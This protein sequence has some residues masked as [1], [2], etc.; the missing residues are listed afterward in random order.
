MR[1]MKFEGGVAWSHNIVVQDRLNTC[2]DIK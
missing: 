1:V 2:T